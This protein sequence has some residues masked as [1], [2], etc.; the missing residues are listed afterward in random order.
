MGR[1]PFFEGVKLSQNVVPGGDPKFNVWR[2]SREARKFR[3]MAVRHGNNYF[4]MG[5]PLRI[6]ESCGDH[7]VD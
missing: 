6:R 4:S 1:N 7:S 2:I 5:S 3:S